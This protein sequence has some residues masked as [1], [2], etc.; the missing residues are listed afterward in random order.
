MEINKYIENTISQ[1]KAERDREIAV[2]KQR[3]TA[4]KIAPANA[5]IDKKKNESVVALN[6]WFEQEK[7]KLTLE[8]NAKMQE[9]QKKYEGDRN[10]ILD[11]AEKKKQENAETIITMET[12]EINGK[13]EKAIAQLTAIL[14]VKE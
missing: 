6:S 7:S 1:I 9:L 2:V 12:C 13:Y 4:E 10:S 3:I 5:E 8:F 14:E 11:G